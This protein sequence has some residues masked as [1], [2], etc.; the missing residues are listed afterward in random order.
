M[1]V[2]CAPAVSAVPWMF[3]IQV[4]LLVLHFGHI[5][6]LPWWLLWLPFIIFVIEVFLVIII[7]V[8]ILAYAG[9]ESLSNINGVGIVCAVVAMV[10]AIYFLII[11]FG[12]IANWL[13]TLV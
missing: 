8:A 11:A 7:G 1:N 13:M 5:A 12:Y 2:S 4:A 9:G 10:A 6:T 3:I